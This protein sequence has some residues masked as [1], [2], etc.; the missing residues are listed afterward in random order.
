M[1]E[2]TREELLEVCKLLDD[3]DCCDDYTIGSDDYH[4]FWTA[5][6]KAREILKKEKSQ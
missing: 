3:I 5:Q 6:E 1:K 2:A 4:K